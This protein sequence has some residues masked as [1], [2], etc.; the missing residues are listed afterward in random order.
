VQYEGREH[1][2]RY[3]LENHKNEVQGYLRPTSYGWRAMLAYEGWARGGKV[4][5]VSRNMLRVYSVTQDRIDADG[6]VSE[7]KGRKVETARGAHAVEVAAFR[8]IYGDCRY[9]WTEEPLTWKPCRNG[10]G[11]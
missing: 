3:Y 4:V 7:Y 8:L 6:S 11:Q 2:G 9:A 5:R 1:R 10:Q